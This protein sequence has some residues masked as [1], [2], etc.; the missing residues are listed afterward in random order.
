VIVPAGGGPA[1][2]FRP[3]FETAAFPIWLPDSSGLLFL[4]R[5]LDKNGHSVGPK[6]VDWWV[7]KLNGEEHATGA[8]QAFD[9]RKLDP[10]SGAFWIRPEAW[11]NDGQ[12]VLFSATHKDATNVW[13]VGISP[14]GSITAAPAPITLGAGT[15]ERPSAPVSGDEDALVF[16]RLETVYQLRRVPLRGDTAG[17]AEPL[18]PGISQVGSPSV[19]TDGHVLVYSA[20]QPN[21]YRVVAVDPATTDMR[22]VTTVESSEPV[23]VLVSGDGKVVVYGAGQVDYRMKVN[24]GT[25]EQICRGCGP[26]TSVNVD[27]S[28]ALFESQESDEHLIEWIAGKGESPFLSADPKNRMQYAGRFSPNGK[29]VAFCAGARDGETREIV[30]VPNA[31]GRTLRDDEWIP[32]SDADSEDR[33]PTWSADGRRLF[34]IS[35]RDGFR[36]IWARDVDPETGRPMRDAVPIAH[37]HH[38]SELLGSPMAGAGGIGLTAT[39]NSLIFTVERSAGNLWWQRAAVR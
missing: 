17:S 16:S 13:H 19:S 5:K 33:G 7:A 23:H 29:W 8:L 38:T 1:R 22:A 9:D 11:Q 36:C 27:G 39:A 37:F 10:V 4:G 2:P 26:P 32:I 31:P 6:G 14:R 25:P 15:D 20:R 18:L 24:Q 21:G 28:A 34:F 35:N 12:G 30:I 3:D